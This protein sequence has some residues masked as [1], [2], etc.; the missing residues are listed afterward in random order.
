MDRANPERL[1]A[2]ENLQQVALRLTELC[3]FDGLEMVT[4][5]EPNDLARLRFWALR[6]DGTEMQLPCGVTSDPLPLRDL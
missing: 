6:V 4:T 3:E 2:L 5:F 1:E